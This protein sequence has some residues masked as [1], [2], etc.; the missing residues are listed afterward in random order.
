VHSLAVA[1]S[2]RIIATGGDDGDVDLWSKDGRR[3]RILH[4]GGD[5]ISAG[6]SPDGRLLVISSTDGK[7]RIWRVSDGRSLH[8]L[9]GHEGPVVEAAFS[10][11][12]R[13]V[14]TVGEDSTARIWDARTGESLA[15]G[16]LAGGGTLT[17][18]AFNPSGTF[19]ATAAT[20]GRVR[21]WRV[22][23]GELAQDL[24]PHVS[25]ISDIAFSHDG[26]WLVT[27]GPTKAAVLRTST[28]QPLL[29]LRGHK[30]PF[31]SVTFSPH[32]MRILTGGEDGSVR[33][34]DCRLCSRLPGLIAL[35][36]Q[37][38]EQ[39]TPRH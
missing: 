25:V 7:A 36:R 16:P 13:Y 4:N 21:I 33:T 23:S 30:Q 9:T 15:G 38:L 20:N 11:D 32:G 17:S 12:G 22:P 5:V 37:R 19:L 35:A 24:Y 27:A 1:S 34:Y 3:L 31:T 6:F 2:G 29:L 28:G 14:A 39:L 8:V 18:L 10:P 26:R